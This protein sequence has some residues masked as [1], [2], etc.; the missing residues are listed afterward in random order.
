M[1]PVMR[2]LARTTL[3]LVLAAAAVLAGCD[4]YEVTGPEMHVWQV[5]SMVKVFQDTRP[6]RQ[7]EVLVLDAARN[8]AVSAQFGL[9]AGER[10]GRT[11]CT[12]GALT[13]ASGATLPAPRARYVAYVPVRKTTDW[14]ALRWAPARYPDPLM[15]VPP[16]AVP[17]RTTQ[18]VWLTVRVPADA[19]PGLYTGEV[20]FRSGTDAA[21]RPLSVRVWP[22]TL[23]ARRTLNVTQW[24]AT[25]NRGHMEKVVDFDWTP[26]DERFW[27]LV[28]SYARTMADHRQTAIYTPLDQYIKGKAGADGK[29]AFDFALFDR[30][31]ETFR[32]A[33]V[34]GRIEGSHLAH[35][36]Y[37]SQDHKSYVWRIENG[38]PVHAKAG[39][40][41][42]EYKAYLA[43]FLPALQ[44]HLAEKGWLDDYMQHLLDEPTKKNHRRYAELAA[45]VR[46][47]APRIRIIDAVHYRGLTGS[48]DIWV[49]QLDLFAKNRR[50]F[51]RRQAAGDEVWFYT[52][53]GPRR[54]YMNR[55]V[56][57]PLLKVRLLHWLGAKYGATG[58]LHWGWNQWASDDPFN[59]IEDHGGYR[60]PAG[61][62]HIVYP[63][64]GGRAIDSLRHEAMLEGSQD[65]ELLA[66]LAKRDP[67]RAGKIIRKL[68]LTPT[69][70]STSV[71]KF[72]AA[73]RQLLD[74]LS[75]RSGPTPPARSRGG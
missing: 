53:L 25:N 16:K 2:A 51:R 9:R 58:Y 70:Y 69:W 32:D 10:L 46:R 75:P 44:A 29:L 4:T 67:K 19:P 71:P 27:T 61:D 59:E 47:H 43:V 6:P 12:V 37:G 55:F 68:I 35:G 18:P 39:S 26:T 63:G 33:G 8:E 22:V 21:R 17:A 1:H 23:P 56:D 50:F 72:R 24:P 3:A 20:V 13:T 60:L 5:D 31:V 34:V 64:P 14:S 52:C 38:E 15:D 11:T 73:R 7:P 74:A 49:P 65:Y 45:E 40:W 54:P 57:Y 48:V 28:A 62:S 42:P 66:L 41:S 30:W 36:P